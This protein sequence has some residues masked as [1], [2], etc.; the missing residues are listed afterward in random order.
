MV[1]SASRVGCRPLERSGPRCPPVPAIVW[2]C[3]AALVGERLR[4]VLLVADGSAGGDAGRQRLRFQIGRPRRLVALPDQHRERRPLRRPRWP[5]AQGRRRG[6]RSP[7][8]ATNGTISSSTT[9]QQRQPDDEPVLDRWAASAPAARSTTGNTSPAAGR[10]CTMVGSASAPS[11]LRPERQI[12]SASTTEPT[13]SAKTTSR[14]AASGQNGTPFA[15]EQ[16][17]VTLRV[18]SRVDRPAPARAA[19]RCRGGSRRYRCTP[20][21]SEHQAPGSRRRGWRRSASASRRRPCCRP[22]RDARSQPP[23]E[24]HAARLF[25]RHDHRPV[26]VLVPAQQ[27][28]GEGHAQ[29]E[30]AAGRRR[31]A[32]STRAGT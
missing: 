8:L 20:I 3:D 18:R 6:L 31:S 24:R 27:L 10:R 9:D 17:V 2:Q 21:S 32:S 25:G 14:Q 19:R 30:Q 5:A 15:L 23:I 22:R 11:S 1:N 28:A 16:R 7:S 13:A 26:G 12:A 4:A 29:R